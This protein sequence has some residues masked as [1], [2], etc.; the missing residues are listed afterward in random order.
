MKV[1][2]EV[3]M[4]LGLQ[5]KRD[6]EKRLIFINQKKYITKVLN[7]FAPDIQNAA[8]TPWPPKKEIPHNWKKGKALKKTGSLNYISVGTRPNIT[9]TVQKICKA[10]SGPIS[11][12]K[13]IIKHL[14]KYLY[15]TKKLAIRLGGKY[16][17]NNLNPRIINRLEMGSF[18]IQQIRTDKIT[19][20]GLTKPL[21]KTAHA[22]F[23]K[24]L[25]IIMME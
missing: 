17:Y 11:I 12:H 3:E 10:N 16:N 7:K 2:G 14:F 6:R 21:L 20:D 8:T 9:Y 22:R 18:K 1:L 24:L 25:G 15:G 13:K 23:M 5:I 4:F 19:A